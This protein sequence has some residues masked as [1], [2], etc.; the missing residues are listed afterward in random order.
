MKASLGLSALILALFLV[1]T[2]AF[3]TG[4]SFFSSYNWNWSN[5]HE[6]TSSSSWSN[7]DG[8][9]KKDCNPVPEPSAAL[10][11]A[12]G[13]LVVGQGVRRSRRAH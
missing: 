7:Y 3:A 1:A 13:A 10:V 4:F 6:R 2:P 5:Y 9:N 8:Y 11:F 12:I